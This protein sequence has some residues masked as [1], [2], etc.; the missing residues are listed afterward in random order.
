MIDLRAVCESPVERVV[1]DGGP[2][3][4][5]G[6]MMLHRMKGGQPHG[7]PLRDAFFGE[8]VRDVDLDRG[9]VTV[10]P[11]RTFSADD[12]RGRVAEIG[13]AI[14]GEEGNRNREPFERAVAQLLQNACTH[15]GAG[16]GFVGAIRS[17]FFASLAVIDD[18][19]GITASFQHVFD[20]INGLDLSECLGGRNPDEAAIDWARLEHVTS[21]RGAQRQNAGQGLPLVIDAATVFCIA[22]GNGFFYRQQNFSMFPRF[23]RDTVKDR[24]KKETLGQCS[25]NMKGVAIEAY[26]NLRHVDTNIEARVP[27][28]RDAVRTSLSRRY[29]PEIAESLMGGTQK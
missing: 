17:D 11:F 2:A 15:S 27:P 1:D 8:V 26:F 20:S 10:F 6:L 16:E 7:G 12:I 14:C 13:Q 29:C 25:Q 23:F 28:T 4:A 3:T 24:T 19:Q 22:S 21:A 5:G 9:T 18:G